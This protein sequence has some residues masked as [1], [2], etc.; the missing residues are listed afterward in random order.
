MSLVA[1]PL[2]VILIVVFIL[3]ESIPIFLVGIIELASIYFFGRCYDNSVPIF[4]SVLV[5]TIFDCSI[6]MFVCSEPLLI[7][8]FVLPPVAAIS[9]VS[10]LSDS[11][12]ITLMI[13]S[14]F[15][16]NFFRP[17]SLLISLNSHSLRLT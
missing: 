6:R 15:G 9:R 17:P 2:P 12:L 11:M 5:L 8:R 14:S 7:F 10:V 16:R 1:S 4:S 3:K 13:L